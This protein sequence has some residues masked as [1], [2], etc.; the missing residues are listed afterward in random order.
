MQI[1]CISRGSQGRGEEFAKKLAAK[2]DYECVSREQFLEEATRQRIPIGKLETA[3]IKPHIFNDKLAL[4]LEHYKALAT[5]ILCEKALNR[6]IVYHGRTG[7]L[8][9]PGINHIL[10]LRVVCDQEFRIQDVMQRLQLPREKAK[11]YLEQVDE[12]R[13][14]WVKTFYNVEWDV[15]TLYD[16]VV[17]LS[18]VNVDNAATAICNMAQLPEFQATPASIKALNDLYLASR[19]RL[20]L[21]SDK[22]TADMNIKVRVS[23]RVI[24][25]T[26]LIQQVKDAAIINEVLQSLKDA[27]EIVCTEAQT[28]ILWIQEDYNAEDNSYKTVLDLA[29]TWDAAVEL[30][31]LTPDNT[32]EILP[33]EEKTGDRPPETWR[34]TGI[35]E[36]NEAAESLDTPGLAKTY[37]N[38]VRDGRAGGKRVITGSQKTL[39]NAIDRSLNYRLVIFDNVF[40]GKG[41]STKKRLLQEWSN[42]LTESLK[43]PVINLDEIQSKYKFGPKQLMQLV[44]FGLLTALVI[45]LI[46]TFEHEVINF[47]A[48]PSSNMRIIAMISIVIFVPC[49]AFLYGKVAGLFLK[50]IKL[51]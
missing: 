44:S 3:I 17:N 14:K 22:R 43:T 39:L 34:Q 33:E 32:Q 23:D 37:E 47:L 30:L 8:L 42:L 27:R 2:L 16:L 13:R 6:N 31:K 48:D 28:N 9:L 46:F 5:S 41:A 25:I 1:I 18:Q 21:A 26:Y 20:L 35:I 38:L 51:D 50:M 40:L 45:F 24:Y 49:F 11:R 4:E 19:A 29:N 10:K 15:F 12:D 7:H 36:E